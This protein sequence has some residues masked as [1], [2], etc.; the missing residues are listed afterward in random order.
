M[1]IL[2]LTVF[3]AAAGLVLYDETAGRRTLS[4]TLRGE[5][6]G[7]DFTPVRQYGSTLGILAGVLLVL[8]MISDRLAIMAGM[9]VL[10]SILL[11]RR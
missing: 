8:Y 5:E 2:I 4:Q 3:L 10:V 1:K 7:I 9:L 6:G 11:M